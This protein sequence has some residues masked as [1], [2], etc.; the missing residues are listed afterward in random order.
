MMETA[1]E[2]HTT[3]SYHASQESPLDHLPL[4]STQIRDRVECQGVAET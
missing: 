3:A 4:D 1:I 2:N